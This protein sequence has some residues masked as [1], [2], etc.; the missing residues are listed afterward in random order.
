MQIETL[1]KEVTGNA[2]DRDVLFM[3]GGVALVV[4]GAGLILTNPN[5]RHYMGRLGLGNALQNVMPD[6]ERYFRLRTM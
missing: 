1:S 6:V 5:V 4:F 3:L 2:S